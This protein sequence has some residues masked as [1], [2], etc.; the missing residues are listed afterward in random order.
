MYIHIKEA[1]IASI[2]NVFSDEDNCASNPCMN[3]GFCV[4]SIGQYVC[5]C[6]IGYSGDR[7]EADDGEAVRFSIC[8]II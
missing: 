6:S 2:S 7:C 8:C 5:H 1:S 3:G 4:D